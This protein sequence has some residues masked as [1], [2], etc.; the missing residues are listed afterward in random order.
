MPVVDFWSWEIL[1]LHKAWWK[2]KPDGLKKGNQLWQLK[3]ENMLVFIIIIIILT[4]ESLKRLWKSSCTVG[5]Y[6]FAFLYIYICTK[7]I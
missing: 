2:Q 4:R 1:V 7:H 6:L 3:C 5:F